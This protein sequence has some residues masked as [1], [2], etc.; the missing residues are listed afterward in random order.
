[1]VAFYSIKNTWL[2]DRK[3]NH[4]KQVFTLRD[5]KKTQCPEMVAKIVKLYYLR[6]YEHSKFF[7]EKKRKFFGNILKR[8]FLY[9]YLLVVNW[10]MVKKLYWSNFAP[11]KIRKIFARVL[12]NNSTKKNV[13]EP[14]NI[15]K[16]K[17]KNGV[18]SRLP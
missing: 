10:D 16:W 8:K 1:M 2:W 18:K 3:K 15:K 6:C 12:K 11:P 17:S 7:R 14:W 5:I 9:S 13:F 4:K